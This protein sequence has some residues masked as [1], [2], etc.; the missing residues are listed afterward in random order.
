M[1][2][3]GR[4]YRRL[5][6]AGKGKYGNSHVIVSQVP[7]QFCVWCK[8]EGGVYVVI[9]ALCVE[10]KIREEEECKQQVQ[11]VAAIRKEGRNK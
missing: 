1:V 5:V 4:R 9:F 11:T 6:V 3:V 2:E 7:M 8:F 10:F